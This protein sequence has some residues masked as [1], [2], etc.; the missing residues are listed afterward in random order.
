MA[1]FVGTTQEFHHFIGPRIRNLV[2]LAAA[3][4]RKRRAGIC[5]DCGEKAELQSAHVHGRGRRTIIEAVLDQYKTGENL[6]SCDLEQVE[7]QILDGHLPIEETFKFLCHPCHV[8]YDASQPRVK[9]KGHVGIK[10]KPEKSLG[11]DEFRK[12]GRIRLWAVRPQNACSQILSAFFVLEKQDGAVTLSTLRDYC[13][14]TLKLNG[15][16]GKYA[17]M[18]TDAGNSYGK[19]FFDDGVVVNLWPEV[20]RETDLYFNTPSLTGN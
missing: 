13:T 4:H 10:T 20:R 1:K 12:L 7:K 2:N 16:D 11:N 9:K 5:E 15:F 18:K 3:S 14:N 19:V 17:S 6:L 8:A